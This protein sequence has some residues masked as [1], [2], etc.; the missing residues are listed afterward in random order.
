MKSVRAEIG[1][2]RRDL[3][4]ELRVFNWRG[5]GLS[6]LHPPSLEGDLED[7]GAR[8]G[9]L[10]WGGVPGLGELTPSRSGRAGTGL[11]AELRCCELA[12]AC[13]VQP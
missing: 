9:A 11:R 10:W 13:F 8:G 6:G 1:R 2:C 3:A 4:G 7:A 5:L 12:L